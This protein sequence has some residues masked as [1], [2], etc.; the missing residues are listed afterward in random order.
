MPGCCPLCDSGGCR[1]T[2]SAVQQKALFE[3][4]AS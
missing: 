1:K 3:K 4:V 2:G